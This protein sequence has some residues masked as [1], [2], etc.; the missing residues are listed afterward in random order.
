MSDRPAAYPSDQLRSPSRRPARARHGPA[1]RRSPGLGP[2]L[3]AG[4]VHLVRRARVRVVA[5]PV[6]GRALGLASWAAPRMRPAWLH[7]SDGV[8]ELGAAPWTGRVL[9]PGLFGCSTVLVVCFLAWVPRR[10]T[11]CTALG[12]G[13]LYGGLPHGFLARGALFGGGAGRPSVAAG[14]AG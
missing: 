12:A 6:F 8:R 4:H 10:G 7:H 11:G 14:A 3:R 1:R 9:T 5:V 2:H 13:T